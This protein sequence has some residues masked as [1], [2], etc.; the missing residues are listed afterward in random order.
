[1]SI[2]VD[3]TAPNVSYI[4]PHLPN[5]YSI[6]VA[7]NRF[8]FHG[9]PITKGLIIVVPHTNSSLGVS[10]RPLKVVIR[11][12]ARPSNISSTPEWWVRIAVVRQASD[13]AV[14]TNSA[15]SRSCANNF[16]RLLHNAALVRVV[17][18][19]KAVWYLKVT[20]VAA[21]FQCRSIRRQVE[22]LVI[23]PRHAGRIGVGQSVGYG[24]DLVTKS[25]SR[26][27]C[28]TC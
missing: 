23:R 28:R 2:F 4:F 21:A 22:A 15:D 1:M 7:L 13:L 10:K 24:L 6:D 18:G 16:G 26:D 3:S 25:L 5:M 19:L 12:S 14:R 17:E 20:D 27:R 9:S 8:V 11:L